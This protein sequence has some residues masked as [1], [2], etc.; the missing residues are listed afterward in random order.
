MASTNGETYSSGHEACNER[1]SEAMTKHHADNIASDHPVR[2]SSCTAYGWLAGTAAAHPF[3][4]DLVDLSGSLAP[5][6]P[7]A[8][9]T[10]GAPRSGN[11]RFRG[12]PG[13]MLDP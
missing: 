4:E 7:T 6:R 8:L 2:R 13:G 5:P 11:C 9:F 3:A 1:D 10:R 12:R